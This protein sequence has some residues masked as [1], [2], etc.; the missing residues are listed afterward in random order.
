MKEELGIDAEL[1]EK[2]SFI[3]K[4]DVGNGLWEHELDHV[5]QGFLKKNFTLIKMK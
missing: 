5:L 4:A 2:F 1:S 3:Y